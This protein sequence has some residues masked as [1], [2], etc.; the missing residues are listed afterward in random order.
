MTKL[1]NETLGPRRC[2]NL[3]LLLG[4]V[5]AVLGAVAC[6]TNL[7]PPPPDDGGSGGGAGRGGAAG[8]GTGGTKGDAPDA[9]SSTGIPDTNAPAPDV[10]PTCGQPGQGCCPG[11]RCLMGGC[12]ERG[13]CTSYGT[14]CS[15][16]PGFSCLA[17]TCSNE[18]GGVV[19]GV[20]MKCCSQHNC[21]SALTVCDGTGAAVGACVNCGKPGLPC[22]ADNAGV[23]N[24]CEGATCSA[25]RCPGTAPPDAAAPADA[26]DGPTADAPR[27]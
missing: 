26:K 22:C 13:V 17:G 16:S 20:S 8:G 6:R 23:S 15:L 7:P 4:L 21:T 19:N 5:G 1:E 25:G 9:P 10:A 18:C 14:V 24:Y 3:L 2:R 12:C 11:N 27:G